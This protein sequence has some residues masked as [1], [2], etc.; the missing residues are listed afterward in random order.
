M[1]GKWRLQ[2]QTTFEILL[3]ETK[4]RMI[5]EPEGFL[6]CFKYVYMSMGI[7]QYI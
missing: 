4:Q 6:F 1:E 3:S 2:E 7:I 5:Q